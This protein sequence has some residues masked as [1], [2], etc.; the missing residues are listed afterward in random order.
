MKAQKEYFLLFER[1]VNGIKSHMCLE[2]PREMK[3]GPS[4]G[5]YLHRIEFWCQCQVF[6]DD[7]LGEGWYDEGWACRLFPTSKKM[8]ITEKYYE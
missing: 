7:V 4:S 5:S 6:V 3:N 1:D 2:L 8:T